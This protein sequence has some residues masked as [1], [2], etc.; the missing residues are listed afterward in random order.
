[1]TGRAEE[2]PSPPADAELLRS[3][4][5]ERDVPCP[6]CGYN[7]RGVE[8]S[9]CPEC[10]SAIVFGLV[11]ARQTRGIRFAIVLGALCLAA[12]GLIAISQGLSIVLQTRSVE[13]FRQSP[14][15][16][17][18]W[19][20]ATSVVILVAL[21]LALAALVLPGHRWPKHRTTWMLILLTSLLAAM[22]AS[23]VVVIMM[24]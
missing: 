16:M 1:M 18:I 23:F 8:Q 12:G 4:L 14:L 6:K 15:W 20:V 11:G 3:Y 24:L 13:V 2:S 5:A 22:I 10:G 19:W 9:K 7:L 17:Q 21:L